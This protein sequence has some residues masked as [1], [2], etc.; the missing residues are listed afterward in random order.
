[1][2]LSSH[3]ALLICDNVSMQRRQSDV[4]DSHERRMAQ[5]PAPRLANDHAQLDLALLTIW[6]CG[7]AKA[8]LNSPSP[9]CGN[10]KQAAVW[11]PGDV[12]ASAGKAR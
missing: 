10:S 1:M 4:C 7:A 11:Q 2:E 12:K 5:S 3:H 8:L 9:L 6:M